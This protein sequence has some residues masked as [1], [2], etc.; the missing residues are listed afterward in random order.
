MLLTGN[1]DIH[2]LPYALTKEIRTVQN[3]TYTR[4]TAVHTY[5]YRL[6]YENAQLRSPAATKP[7]HT[8]SRE[9]NP[10]PKTPL[11]IFRH[12][13]PDSFSPS[14]RRPFNN[15]SAS[16]PNQNYELFQRGAQR[17]LLQKAARNIPHPL[18][19]VSRET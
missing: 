9:L 8:H 17:L 2:P 6:Y 7:T 18:C 13:A 19:P 5:M 15:Q 12:P 10:I 3:N 14:N 11:F 16:H 4:T 1:E